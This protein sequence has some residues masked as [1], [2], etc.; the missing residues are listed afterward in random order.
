MADFLTVNLK[1]VLNKQK[2]LL[3]AGR[4][5]NNKADSTKQ[6]PNAAEEQEADLSKISDWEKELN[7]RLAKN[8]AVD[9]KARKSDYAV[10]AKFFEDYFKTNWEPDC[11][12]QLLSLGDPL[13]KAIKVLKF[14]RK[15]NPILGFISN[16]YV[17][18]KL[19]KTQLLDENTFKAI[20]SAV[21]K[22][23]V[24]QSEFMTS[25]D[26]NI[27]YCQDLYRRSAAEIEKYLEL[28]SQI[29]KPSANAYTAEDIEKNKKVFFY[30]KEVKAQGNVSALPAGAVLPSAKQ[31]ST[32]MNSL[33]LAKALAGVAKEDIGTNNNKG[34]I[35][36]T[37]ATAALAKK[38]SSNPAHAFAAI[39]YLNAITDIPEAAK[40]LKHEAFKSI[41]ITD[42]IS[43]S[44]A[45]AKAMKNTELSD[46]EAKQFI[47]TLLNRL[48][49]DS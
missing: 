44:A 12:K 41:P 47:E 7:D 3:D 21:S 24:A 19:I 10:E 46:A 28:Q 39:Q 36:S 15:V 23:L 49:S 26:S 33:A 32:K 34:N 45:V 37:G 25:N 11:A 27:I 9:A 43:A 4:A 2:S 16:K 29:L 13:K 18:D 31:A 17:I 40:A 20:Y 30:I 1:S 35:G 8:Q 14:N 22:R 42:L 5:A 6:T 48:G 38:L